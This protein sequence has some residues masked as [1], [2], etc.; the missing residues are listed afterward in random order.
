MKTSDLVEWFYGNLD[1]IEE[2]RQNGS[3]PI[4]LVGGAS[5]SGKS[6]LSTK[7]KEFLAQNGYNSVIISTDS[8]NK[9]IS[10]NIFD[11]VNKKY[12]NGKIKYKPLIVKKIKN[13]IQDSKF[14]DKFCENNLL[15]IKSECQNLLNAEPNT[16]L[17][18]MKYEFEH[19]N[20]DQ[21]SIYDLTNA[22]TDLLK[23][24][25]NQTIT[26][27]IYSKMISE[28]IKSDKIIDGKNLDV[29]IVEG[30]YALDKNITSGLNKNTVIK[31]YIDCNHKNLFLR[32][33]IRD[34]KITDCPMSFILKNYLDYVAPEYIN[35]VLPYRKDADFV[36]VNNMTLQELRTGDTT[37]Q[38]KYLIDVEILKEILKTFKLKN[39]IYQI[40]TYFGDK[41]DNNILRLR[42]EGT[43]KDG[44]RLSSLTY[45]GTPKVRKDKKNIRVEHTIASGD[46]LKNIFES[47]QQLVEQ[48]KDIGLDVCKTIKKERWQLE[49][50]NQQIKI[51]FY[52]AKIFVEVDDMIENELT[53]L[54]QSCKKTNEFVKEL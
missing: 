1:L 29:I 17:K 5:S 49:S 20:F 36:F 48:F 52:K 40:D 28:R 45:K 35:T 26:E 11:I 44:L 3:K 51:D 30:I 13:I 7:L 19:I 21:K 8:Y 46:D 47:K 10:E 25:N 14:E 38:Q 12:Y 4:V 37:T 16:F 2:C 54:L 50:N 33:M 24:A 22:Q 23:L 43:N 31:N 18:R 27:P 15:K 34:S 41:S 39:K 32:R 53:E 9:G 6:Y 42:E